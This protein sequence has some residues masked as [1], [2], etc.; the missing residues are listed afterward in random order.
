METT[1]PTCST[2]G[3]QLIGRYVILE[4]A[5]GCSDVEPSEE[6]WLIAGAGTDKTKDYSIGSVTSDA[7]NTGGIVETLQTNL[8]VEIG[9]SG[10]VLDL[11]PAAMYGLERMEMN[12]VRRSKLMQQPTLWLRFTEGDVI[13]KFFAVITSLS[14]SGGTNDIR[15]F[16]V[17]FKVSNASTYSITRKSEVVAP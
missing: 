6:D 11:S 8:D 5:D 13:T 1:F 10:E 2:D 15:T 12:V 4:L 9:F 14:T 16:D 17:S 7:D 3:G